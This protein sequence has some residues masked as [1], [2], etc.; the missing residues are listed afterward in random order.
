MNENDNG[1]ILRCDNITYNCTNV[2]EYINFKLGNFYMMDYRGYTGTFSQRHPI[3]L[4]VICTSI[5]AQ[6]RNKKIRHITVELTIVLS[7]ALDVFSIGEIYR[8]YSND[9]GILDYD[10]KWYTIKPLEN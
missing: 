7:S 4:C 2:K 1:L 3:S 10:S 9:N 6:T 5:R 8:I